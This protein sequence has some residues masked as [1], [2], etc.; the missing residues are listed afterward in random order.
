MYCM[1]SFPDGGHYLPKFILSWPSTTAGTPSV[2][3]I[4][5]ISVW[6]VILKQVRGTDRWVNAD[7]EV[8]EVLEALEAWE[9]LEVLEVLKV[10]K[11]LKALKVLSALV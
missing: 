3:E 11:V 4:C 8:L 5:A 7:L 6:P 2:L 10:L 9:V 1:S